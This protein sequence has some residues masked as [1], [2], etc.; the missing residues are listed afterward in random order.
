[1]LKEGKFGV[2]EAI[3]IATIAMCNKIFSTA[4]GSIMR[5]VG[6]AAWYTTLLSCACAAVFFTFIYLLLKRF[7]GKNIV[8]VYDL[9]L[10]R[11]T[12]FIFSFALMLT[13]LVYSGIYTREYVDILKIYNFEITPPSVL[14]GAIV[15]VVAISAFLGLETIARTAKLAAYFALFGFLLLLFLSSNYFRVAHILPVLG[16][17]LGKTVATGILR[18]TAYAEVVVLAVF[19]GSLQGV[20]HIKKA[21]FISLFLS[22]FILSLAV[23]I[24]SLIFE[25]TSTEEITAPMY[26]M[27]RMIKYGNFFQRL[28]PLFLLLW[29]ITTV[30]Y[31]SI[32]FY[33]TV[34][35]YCK[36]FR[37]QDARP[38]IIPMSVLVFAIAIFPKDFPSI[39]SEYVQ[40]IRIWG[41]I[42]FFILPIIALIVAVLRKKKGDRSNA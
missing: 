3:C 19:A 7:P 4:P 38:V 32:L 11:V 15:I 13:F 26:V 37:L 25:Y 2:H 31:I 9:S 6:T 21:G 27:I 18:S 10:G 41:N 35:I 24:F 28:D 29:V 23:L 17:G 42:P 30:I 39:V 33:V 8:E 16:Y 1:M 12:G 20:R 5:S 40:R 36:M 34:S 14:I 22:G